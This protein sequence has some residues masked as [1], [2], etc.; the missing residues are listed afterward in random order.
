LVRRFATIAVA[1]VVLTTTAVALQLHGLAGVD[2]LDVLNA[3]DGIRLPLSDAAARAYAR[4]VAPKGIM[5]N[6]NFFNECR[7]DNSIVDGVPVTTGCMVS[8]S[9]TAQG[10]AEFDITQQSL[11]WDGK[12]PFFIAI[13]FTAWNVTPSDVKAVAD[14]LGQQGPQYQVVRADQYFDLVRKANGL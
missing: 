4:D 10:E 5:L 7:T 11:R 12:S 3:P 13:E 9:S 6:Y 2:T 8:S 14:W 1:L